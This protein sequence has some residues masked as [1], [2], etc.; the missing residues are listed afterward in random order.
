VD[1]KWNLWKWTAAAETRNSNETGISS[2]VKET[3]W[4]D[5]G[6]GGGGRDGDFVK[7]PL[8]D[9]D[10]P[11]RPTEGQAG[12]AA[13]AVAVVVLPSAGNGKVEGGTVGSG[14]EAAKTTERTD[15]WMATQDSELDRSR[16]S[17]EIPLLRSLEKIPEQ[18]SIAKTLA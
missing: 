1:E 2:S 7:T 16:R 3:D 9:C 12:G 15:G 10:L 6:G 18:R 8:V 14:D 11:V 4:T 13:G 5:G 17:P